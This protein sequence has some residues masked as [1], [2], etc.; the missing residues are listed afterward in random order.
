MRDSAS[1]TVKQQTIALIGNPNSGKTT[2]FNALTGLRQKIGNYPG[3][4][5]ERKEGRVSLHDGR[6]LLLLDLPGIYSLN[7]TSADERIAT[8][9][10][11][12]PSHIHFQARSCGLHRRCK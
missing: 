4:T 2:I 7:A 10:L 1:V 8:E 11:L 6:S 3:V 9:I 12:W 5:V